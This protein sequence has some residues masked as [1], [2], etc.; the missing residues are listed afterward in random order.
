M[1]S[2]ESNWL[3]VRL[4]SS[5]TD[6]VMEQALQS[7]APLGRS[8]S[9]VSYCVS[10]YAAMCMSTAMVLNRILVF[11]SSRRNRK[12]PLVSIV[13]LRVL[14]LFILFK[15]SYGVISCIKSYTHSHLVFRLIPDYYQFDVK[16]FFQK[17]FLNM[18]YGTA[19]WEDKGPTPTVLKPFYLSLC[20]SQII[21]T[22]IAIASGNDPSVESGI[23]LFEYSLAFQEV[24]TSKRPSRELLTLAFASLVNHSLIHIL[25]L[26]NLEKYR[27]IPSSIV[28]LAVL[29]YVADTI[30]SLRFRLMPFVLVVGYLPQLITLFIIALCTVIFVL[31]SVFKG[32]FTDSTFATLN[33][34]ESLNISL[35]DDFQSTL[36]TLGGFAINATGRISYNREIS[37]IKIPQTTWVD[38]KQSSALFFED[39]QKTKKKL[40]Y[41]NDLQYHPDMVSLGDLNA[42]KLR[43]WKLLT[44]ARQT[45]DLLVDMW[46]LVL[47]LALRRTPKFLERTTSD[48]AIPPMTDPRG[49]GQIYNQRKSY[50]NA[51]AFDMD[52]YSYA[53]LLLGDDLQDV[54]TSLDFDEATADESDPDNVA[55]EYQS[56]YESDIEIIGASSLALARR[57]EAPNYSKQTQPEAIMSYEEL[58]ALLSPSTQ[59]EVRMARIMSAHLK[60]NDKPLT[61]SSFSSSA[62]KLEDV[63]LENR[64]RHQSIEDSD[65]EDFGIGTCVVCQTNPRQIILWPCKCLAV[66]DVCRVS[67]AMRAFD[68]C[69]CCRRKVQGYSKI[70]V[71]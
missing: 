66:C 28:G 11:A 45:K 35:S 54:D 4:F 29:Y 55:E 63:I 20:L 56:D 25:S 51:D 27:L 21:E 30:L 57:A 41:A 18:S 39:A 67:L 47:S 22:F 13:V 46:D 64:H 17:T 52:K 70:Y 42:S 2:P 32:S 34:L 71:P 50:V 60:A 40:G 31:A 5:F 38:M 24:Q 43:H 26:G 36:M 7:D 37:G 23:T 69:V 65:D 59:Q 48:G 8:R 1:A 6:G 19:S 16:T 33:N 9:M 15:G 58:S 62:W 68:E 3:I 61:R 10:P 14:A 53:Q 12:L 49:S 44:R